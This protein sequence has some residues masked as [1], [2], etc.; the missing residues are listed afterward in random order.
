MRI[1]LGIFQVGGG[2]NKFRKNFYIWE[3]ME[4]NRIGE[5]EEK[6]GKFE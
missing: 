2:I 6:K 1:N 4:E 3:S 5:G